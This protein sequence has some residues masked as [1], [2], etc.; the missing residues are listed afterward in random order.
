MDNFLSR[1]L[2]YIPG[3]IIFLVGSGQ[4]K[5]W[6]KRRKKDS[7]S[8]A[9][10]ISCEHVIKKDRQG[11]ELMN[12]YD[13]TAEYT[14]LGSNKRVQQTFKSPTEYAPGQQV[15]IFWGSGTESSQLSEK[16]DEAI[17]HPLVMMMGGAL[18]ILLSMFENQKRE[19][20]AMLCLT[21]ILIGAGINLL[22]TYFSLKKKNL[23]R[24]DAEVI[25]IFSRQ[26]S[27]ETKIWKS[28][29]FTYYPI[30]KYEING[31]ENIRRCRI[32]SSSEKSFKRGEKMSLYYE[33]ATGAVLERHAHKGLLI[34]GIIILVIGILA[35][36]SI[37]SVVL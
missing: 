25:D 7:S 8:V 9:D 14:G 3:I 11:R 19:V 28:S 2:P 6:L 27:K 34:T 4:V 29:K 26:L 23:Q 15:R 20:E 37:L 31:R 16:E 10:V 21:I 32:N 30:V 35:G 12:Y 17:F 13:I 24:I 36:L 33:P 1:F 22:Y 18:L 5:G